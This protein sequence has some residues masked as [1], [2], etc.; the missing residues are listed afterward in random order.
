MNNNK[1][2]QKGNEDFFEGMNEDAVQQR[3]N[4]ERRFLS[5]L[6]RKLENKP[7]PWVIFFGILWLLGSVFTDFLFIW[8]FFG[9]NEDRSFIPLTVGTLIILFNIALGVR[10]G[11]AIIRG[12]SYKKNKVKEKTTIATIFYWTIGFILLALFFFIAFSLFIS[13]FS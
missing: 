5:G 3:I 11:I 12:C 6:I 4:S 7:K 8:L 13:I 1:N 9:V 10:I 2:I